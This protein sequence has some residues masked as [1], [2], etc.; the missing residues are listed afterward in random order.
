MQKMGFVVLFL[1]LLIMHCA[2]EEELFFSHLSGWVRREVDSVG[3]NGLFLQIRDIDPDHLDQFR[4]RTTMTMTQDSLEGYF[5]MDSVLYG[6]SQKQGTGYVAIIA[7][8]VYNENWP[9]HIW[10]P[11]ITNDVATIILYI[12]KD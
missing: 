3:V 7:D 9:S 4:E 8:S 2:E 5:E 1:M 10:F 6:T 12:S 11:N